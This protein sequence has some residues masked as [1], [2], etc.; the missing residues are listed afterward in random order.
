[1]RRR[2]VL[3]GLST[4]LV[5]LSGCN[6][7]ESADPSGTDRGRDDRSR[8]PTA[9]PEGTD[10]GAELE[11]GAASVVDLETADRTYA[12]SP[13]T[14]RSDDGAR[15]SVRFASTATA[16]GPATVTATLTDGNPFE[17]TFELEWTPPFGRRTSDLPHPMG[18]RF[19][20]TGSYRVGLAFAPTANHDLVDDPPAVERA[21]DGYCGSPAGSTTGSPS[22]SGWVPARPSTASTLSSVGPTASGAAVHR[23]STSSPG[24]TSDRSG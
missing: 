14:Y 23:A 5:G 18:D 15:V 9:T 17:N 19:G 22:G 16:D 8:T 10:E 3:A 6:S 13:P 11:L 1:M 24:R 20:D 7:R 4:G 12:L 21:A 2:R